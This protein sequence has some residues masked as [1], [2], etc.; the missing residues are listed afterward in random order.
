[1]AAEQPG[2]HEGSGAG[3]GHPPSAGASAAGPGGDPSLRSSADVR[4]GYV[5]GITAFGTKRVRYAAVGGVAMFEGDIALG[6]V[7]KMEQWKASMDKSG[8]ARDMP[9]AGTAAGTTRPPNVASGV[10]IVGERFRWPNAVVPYEVQ[11][12]LEDTVSEALK[13]WEERTTVRFVQRNVGNASAYPNYVSFEAQDGCWSAVGMQGK[14]QVLSL[15]M[16]CGVG[17]A[18]HEIGHAVG[19]WHEQSRED[20]DQFVRIDWANIQAGMEHNFDQHI[21]DGDDIGDYDYGSI[22]HYPATAF[23]STGLPTIVALGGQPI[24]QRDGLSPSD[25]AAVAA[26]YP[27]AVGRGGHFYTTS[28]IELQQALTSFGYRNDGIVCHVWP[29]PVPGG[30]PMFRLT[31][32]QGDAMYTTSVVEAYTAMVND[33]YAFDAIAYYVYPVPALGL[34]P[35]YHLAKE[36]PKDHLYTTSLT[37]AYQALT[38]F[39]YEAV[40]VAGHVLDTQYPGALPLYQLSKAG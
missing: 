21:T 38:H 40:G 32:P 25:I 3:T 1:M 17:Q 16:G 11:A 30:A 4:I 9:A 37:D 15:G 7:E 26:L 18:I 36:E 22:M 8:V 5:T 33:G 14:M 24:G 27:S 23:S 19:L 31:G 13:H 12:G 20:R 2:R 10:A 6:T 39:D 28:P 35:L 29:G 34:T